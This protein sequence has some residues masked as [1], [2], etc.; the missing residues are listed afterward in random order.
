MSF[1]KI[2][3]FLTGTHSSG[4]QINSQNPKIRISNRRFI[5]DYAI[6][7]TF[8]IWSQLVFGIRYLDMNIG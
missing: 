8:E 1:V 5:N 6:T 7:Q 4:T 2:Y 3:I